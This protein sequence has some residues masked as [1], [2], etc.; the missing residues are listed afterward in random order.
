MPITLSF[1]PEMALHILLPDAF[2][3][4]EDTNSAKQQIARKRQHR[5]LSPQSWMMQGR[6][7]MQTACFHTWVCHHKCQPLLM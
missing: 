2:T 4:A 7:V 3:A 1:A 6:V 5:L